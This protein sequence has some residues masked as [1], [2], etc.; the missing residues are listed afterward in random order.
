MKPRADR[1][2]WWEPINAEWK[3]QKDCH[4]IRELFGFTTGTNKRMIDW[5][6]NPLTHACMYDKVNGTVVLVKVSCFLQ[7]ALVS[8]LTDFKILIFV[9]LQV[10]ITTVN[11]YQSVIRGYLPS[12]RTKYSEQTTRQH[13]RRAQ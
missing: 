8:K 2:Q 3:Q 9:D 7:F 6:A 10:V 4:T 13:V 12:F 11:S 1:L 5:P